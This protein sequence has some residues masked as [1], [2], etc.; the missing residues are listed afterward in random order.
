MRFFSCRVQGGALTSQRG[1]EDKRTT[2]D[3][4]CGAKPCPVTATVEY[5]GQ[6]QLLFDFYLMGKLGGIRSRIHVNKGISEFGI[7]IQIQFHQI[8]KIKCHISVCPAKF[9]LSLTTQ[10]AM[11]QQ[12]GTI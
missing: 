6:L 11:A 9:V 5:F 8:A 2:A 1:Y 12:E 7:E 4:R 3:M 10:P